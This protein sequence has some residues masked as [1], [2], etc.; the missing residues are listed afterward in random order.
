MLKY[1]SQ[2]TVCF[3]FKGL[4]ISSFPLTKKK[5]LQAYLY[6]GEHLIYKSKGKDI[7][8][9]I[10]IYTQLCNKIYNKKKNKNKLCTDDHIY[11]LYCLS[12]LLRLKIIQNNE[13]NGYMCF[14]KKKNKKIIS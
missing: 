4:L 9:Q 7:L 2:G 12:A 11:F 5:T 14:G 3:Y 10:K 13:S 8:E 6:H 1:G